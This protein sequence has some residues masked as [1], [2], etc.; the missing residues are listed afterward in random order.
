MTDHHDVI[1]AFVDNEPIEA[2]ELAAAL[3]MPDGRDYLIDMLVL[4]G[5]VAD[6]G[7]RLTRSAVVSKKKT[8]RAVFWLPAVAAALLTIGV[9]TGFVAGRLL[10]NRATPVA[11]VSDSA[12][13]NTPAVVAPAPTHVIRMEKGVDWNERSGGN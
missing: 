7:S 10:S 9:G 6:G 8:S 3:A 1:G 4:R 11:P 13:I 12:D 5:L 2:E